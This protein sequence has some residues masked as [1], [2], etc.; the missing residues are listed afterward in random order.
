MLPGI[1]NCECRR[2]S[3]LSSIYVVSSSRIKR[4]NFS[5]YKTASCASI[6][7]ACSEMMCAVPPEVQQR[8]RRSAMLLIIGGE[9]PRWTFC[10][11]A[12]SRAGVSFS[13]FILMKAFYTI[14]WE[15]EVIKVFVVSKMRKWKTWYRDFESW[16]FSRWKRRRAML[17]Q[18]STV[19]TKNANLSISATFMNWPQ[20][21][22][23]AVL[24]DACSY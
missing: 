6:Y 19:T 4:D 17:K 14:L 5:L 1:G 23:G 21:V 18:D 16:T 24:C 9:N 12:R 15:N 8:T 2:Q 13:R 22:N 20:N 10:S 3:R 11:W 7:Q